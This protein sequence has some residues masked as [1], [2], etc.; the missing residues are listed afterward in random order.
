MSC[1]CVCVISVARKYFLPI[2]NGHKH[3]ECLFVTIDGFEMH[4]LIWT[5]VRIQLVP[6]FWTCMVVMLNTNAS[7]AIFAEIPF[8]L[9]MQMNTY[10]HKN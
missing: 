3:K 5:N 1:L 10:T 7:V 4:L 2:E 6:A 9:R 8:R